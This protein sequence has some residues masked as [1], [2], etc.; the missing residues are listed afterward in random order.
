MTLTPVW[1]RHLSPSC[2]LLSWMSLDDYFF[3]SKTE[4][5]KK[6]IDEFAI[7]ECRWHKFYFNRY[8]NISQLSVKCT[9]CST[10]NHGPVFSARLTGPEVINIDIKNNL[11][12]WRTPC[13]FLNHKKVLKQT[14][15]CLKKWW[16]VH[17]SLL[18]KYSNIYKVSV[19]IDLFRTT[20]IV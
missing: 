17:V 1:V 20:N 11:H 15:I 9:V 14:F 18:I 5:K 10:L 19:D 13:T 4:R 8:I 7:F 3:L 2:D 12:I 6:Q 16:K